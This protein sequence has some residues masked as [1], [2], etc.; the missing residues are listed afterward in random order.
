MLHPID[1]INRNNQLTGQISNP[2]EASNRGLWHRGIHVV[3]Y[4]PD[5]QLLVQKR[6]QSMIYHPGMLDISV[7]GFVD[8]QESPEQAA[9][10]EVREETGITINERNLQL[11]S[12]IKYNHRWKYGKRQKISRTVLYTYI[13]LLEKTAASYVLSPQHSEIAWIGFLPLKSTQ[14]LVHKHFIKRLGYLS[15]LYSYYRMLIRS[16]AKALQAQPDEDIRQTL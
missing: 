4:T 12:V 16:T 2:E 11:V 13:Y 1:I 6:S 14:W 7:G 8:S 10:R 9:A 5:K 15:P 3:M